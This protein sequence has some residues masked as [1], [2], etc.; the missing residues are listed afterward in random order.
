MK[1]GQEV[2]KDHKENGVGKYRNSE[3]SRPQVLLLAVRG[4]ISFK[5]LLAG[6]LYPGR[7]G[8]GIAL[9][10]YTKL[11]SLTMKFCSADF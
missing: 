7:L 2:L 10:S 8:Q 11:Q 3:S 9:P 4:C 1:P 6:A 5:G